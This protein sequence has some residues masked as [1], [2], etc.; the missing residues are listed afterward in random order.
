MP[1]FQFFFLINRLEPIGNY[2]KDKINNDD[3]IHFSC[4]YICGKFYNFLVLEI[5]TLTQMLKLLHL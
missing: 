3:N 2:K 4:Y 5:S 1:I